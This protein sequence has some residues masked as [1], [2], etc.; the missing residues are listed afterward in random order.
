LIGLV[1]LAGC[2]ELLLPEIGIEPPEKKTLDAGCWMLDFGPGIQ[3]QHLCSSFPGVAPRH[4]RLLRIS[5][6]VLKLR[7]NPETCRSH[8]NEVDDPTPLW[9]QTKFQMRGGANS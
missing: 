7:G 3:H 1:S 8:F 6:L 4:K 9:D 2:E 5:S